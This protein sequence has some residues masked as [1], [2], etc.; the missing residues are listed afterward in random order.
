M[1]QWGG[2]SNIRC[3]R[4][5]VLASASARPPWQWLV[6]RLGAHLAPVP[7]A[8]TGY[9]NCRPSLHS[10]LHR[11][12]ADNIRNLTMHNCTTVGRMHQK[13]STIAFFRA[14]VVVWVLCIILVG[15]S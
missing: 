12:S 1:G 6:M 15:W 13:E 2:I 7:G 11:Q 4:S 5:P 3:R 14:F 10:N 9:E 8:E